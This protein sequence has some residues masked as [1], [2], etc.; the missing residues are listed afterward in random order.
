MLTLTVAIA[1]LS[2]LCREIEDPEAKLYAVPVESYQ[3]CGTGCSCLAV[4]TLCFTEILRPDDSSFWRFAAVSVEY[5]LSCSICVCN[6]QSSPQEWQR[7]TKLHLGM[8]A[9]VGFVQ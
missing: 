9:P 6:V 2:Y 7:M 1:E 3:K 8:E 5:A 4:E